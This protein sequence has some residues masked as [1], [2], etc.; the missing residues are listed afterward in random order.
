V[1]CVFSFLSPSLLLP[2]LIESFSQV[3]ALRV[4]KLFPLLR[5]L[6]IC[7]RA[8]PLVRRDERVDERKMANYRPP[9]RNT[10]S[11]Q[12]PLLR[13][14]VRIKQSDV[15][16]ASPIGRELD[17]NR[18]DRLS[19]ASRSA[20]RASE[21]RRGS[22]RATNDHPDF[23]GVSTAA[24]VGRRLGTRE[25]A[26]LQPSRRARRAGSGLSI[27]ASSGGTRRT[28]RAGARLRRPPRRGGIE[29]TLVERFD[30]RHSDG[31]RDSTELPTRSR[32]R[33]T[34][35]RRRRPRQQR[36]EPAATRPAPDFTKYFPRTT[37]RT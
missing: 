21:R 12:S 3:F 6:R 31:G 18:I 10:R 16:A 5:S 14:G 23:I 15:I 19:R 30:R 24:S 28:R 26:G 4:A 22:A 17:E 29:L 25:P 9:R 34:R 36:W 11:S 1:L 2:E 7:Q 27:P 33:T 35:R 37:R 8:E 20:R 13:R 32:T